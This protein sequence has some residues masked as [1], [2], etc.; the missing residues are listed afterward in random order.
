MLTAYGHGTTGPVAI[1]PDA[2]AVPADVDWIDACVPTPAEMDRLGRWLGVRVPTV[3]DLVEIE[4][5]SRLWSQGDTL[6]MSLPATIKD[7]AGYPTATPVGFIV[8][9]ACVATIRFDRLQSFETLGRQVAA[10]GELSRG[11]VGATV[12]ILEAIVDQLADVL[13]RAGGDL[14]AMSRDIFSGTLMSD[15][16]HRPQQANR[17][18]RQLMRKVG[19]TG[20]LISKVSESLLGLSRMT[21]FL[22]AKSLGQLTPQA[23]HEAT[24]DAAPDAA[25][26][27]RTRLDTIGQDARSLH[28]YQE[29]IAS[30]T[31]F[32]LDALLGLANIEQNNVFRVL[33]VVSVVGIPPTFFAS[34][35]GMNFKFMPELEWAHG[36]AYGLTLIACSAILPALWFKVRG[37]W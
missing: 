32:L 12:S 28:D 27:L 29:H 17:A 20:D 13:E 36:Y 25:S 31:Q 11:G 33:T 8:T 10:K 19:R 7:E 5:S 37:W 15:K 16:D 30:K 26:D 24:R 6:F 18:L 35:Y 2:V 4:S 1:A 34:L 22:A 23:A 9:R 21:P 3:D 14:D